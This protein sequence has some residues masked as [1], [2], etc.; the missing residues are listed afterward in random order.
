MN[1]TYIIPVVTDEAEDLPAED[2][3]E[4]LEIEEKRRKREGRAD[5]IIAMQAAVCMIAAVGLIVTN[6]FRPDI[7]GELFGRLRELSESTDELF[8]NP[9]GLIMR[10]F[11]K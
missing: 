4:Q 3:T 8:P 10:L 7:A 11:G 1:E 5:D 6:I 9:I 2:D